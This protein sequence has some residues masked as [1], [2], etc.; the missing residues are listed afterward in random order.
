MI[1]IKMGGEAPGLVE[2]NDLFIFDQDELRKDLGMNEEDE[3]ENEEDE[4]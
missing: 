3:D 1:S 2:L 4:D